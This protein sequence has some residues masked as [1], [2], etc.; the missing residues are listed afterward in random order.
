MATLTQS[1]LQG[2]IVEEKYVLMRYLGGS[3]HSAVFQTQ[4]GGVHPKDAAIKLL[5]APPGN[6]E[7]RLS[8]WRL[9]ANI[10]HPHLMRIVDMGRCEVANAPMLFV[11][12][13]LA[14]E[15]LAEILP[16]RPL[17][18]A[19]AQEMLASLL[20]A[21]VFLH[22]RGF[23]H[24]HI[25]PSNIMAIGDDLKLS[26]DT[27][28]RLGEVVENGGVP[29]VYDAPEGTRSGA[30]SKADIWSLGVTLTEVLTQQKLDWTASSRRDPVLPESIPP[31]FAEMAKHC[32]RRAPDKRWTAATIQSHLPRVIAKPVSSRAAEG[33][34]QAAPHVREA[35]SRTGQQLPR[36]V[37]AAAKLGPKIR[38]ASRA[39]APAAEHVS[40]Q[41]SKIPSL[42]ARGLQ[43]INVPKIGVPH[44]RKYVTGAAVLGVGLVA[45]AAGVK[46]AGHGGS[47]ASP[48]S[49]GSAPSIAVAKPVQPPRHEKLSV[50]GHR[51]RE[52][53]RS[54]PSRAPEPIAAARPS[55]PSTPKREVASSSTG[56]ANANAAAV[57]RS[58]V[59]TPASSSDAA[60]SMGSNGLIGGRVVQ[61]ILPDVPRSASNTIWGTV[62]VGVRVLVDA[63]GN[64]TQAELQSA[65]PSRYFARLSL[66]AA[67]KWHFA[68]PTQNGATVAS[69]WLLHFGYRRTG[70]AVEPSQVK[71]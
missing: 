22:N 39:M 33:I 58:A 63:S 5:P 4:Y 30:S 21:L 45:I 61:R 6:T 46:F 27:I 68:A 15:N 14:S 70:T 47:H 53:A 1:F 55:I 24:G 43:Q 42:I 44:A 65:G 67:R 48:T 52:A 60:S 3:D 16:E 29:S 37:Q 7:A 2:E 62:R 31:G 9:A 59:S 23:V 50:E 36:V 19:E 66:A 18:A 20:D 56:P 8:G 35:L 10:S 40:A 38:E 13:E 41:I 49:V 25:R 32:L 71:P 11:V 12:T 54:E 69:V 28:C 64:V 34:A 57:T 26:A 51:R 17:A